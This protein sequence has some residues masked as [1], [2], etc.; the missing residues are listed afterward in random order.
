[1]LPSAPQPATNFFYIFFTIQIHANLHF[2]CVLNKTVQLME[3]IPGYS[4]P[5]FFKTKN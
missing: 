2:V 5:H 3:N 1:M 4:S